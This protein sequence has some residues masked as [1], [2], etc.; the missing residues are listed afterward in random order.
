MIMSAISGRHGRCFIP[1]ANGVKP[2][3]S[4]KK[5]QKLEEYLL[6]LSD[7]ILLLRPIKVS[8]LGIANIGMIKQFFDFARTFLKMSHMRHRLVVNCRF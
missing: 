6:F 7:T 8:I 5:S 4:G 1:V 3:S 2:Y